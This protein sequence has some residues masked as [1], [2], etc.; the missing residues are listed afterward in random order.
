MKRAATPAILAAVML[1]AVAVIAEAQQAKKVSRIGFLGP[2]LR[3]V[4]FHPQRRISA[5]AARFG[6]Y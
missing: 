5:R 3:I 1:L 2:F 4:S 6:L